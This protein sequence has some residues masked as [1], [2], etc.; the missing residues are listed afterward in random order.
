MINLNDTITYGSCK[1]KVT[2]FVTNNDINKLKEE[3]NDWC[4]I[5]P[6]NG[7]KLNPANVNYNSVYIL[8]NPFPGYMVNCTAE[9]FIDNEWGHIVQAQTYDRNQLGWIGYGLYAHQHNNDKII[10]R[11]GTYGLVV[12]SGSYKNII[13]FASWPNSSINANTAPCRIKA[14]K[15]GKINEE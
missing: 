2:K 4:Y 1:F 8:D 9:L 11:T 3:G 5:Y 13:S 14:W 15:I 10:L 12:M 7:T 6:N